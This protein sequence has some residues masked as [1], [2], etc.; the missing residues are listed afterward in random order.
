MEKT[1][2]LCDVKGVTHS[3]TNPQKPSL[4]LTSF[5]CFGCIADNF[6]SFPAT[7]G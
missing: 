7:S 1:N 6:N 4:L 5:S 2:M 3:E